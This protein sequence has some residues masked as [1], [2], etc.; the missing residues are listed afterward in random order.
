MRACVIAA[1]IVAISQPAFAKAHH[2]NRHH[3]H[4]VKHNH[5]HIRGPIPADF[6]AAMSQTF[7]RTNAT[8]TPTFSDPSFPS[9]S[10]QASATPAPRFEQ[11]GAPAPAA[12]PFGFSQPVPLRT[13]ARERNSALDAMIARH[14]AANGLPVEMVDGVGKRESGSTP[15]A[16][17]RG[18]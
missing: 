2:K 3:T 1:A 17:S 10:A 6:R 16:A 15:S 14:A 11:F 8:D 5:S 12:Q 9:R 4:H 18:S 7:A 13:G